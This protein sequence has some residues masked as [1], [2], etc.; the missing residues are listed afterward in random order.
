MMKLTVLMDNTATL[1]KP[2]L[3]ESGLGFL[4]ET[5]DA[6]IIFDTGYSPIFLS[7]A[8]KMGIDL[9]DATGVVISH[10]HN[11]HTNGLPALGEVLF[12]AG[13]RIPL[14][15]HPGCLEKKWWRNKEGSLEDIGMPGD[16]YYFEKFYDVVMV[17]TPTLLGHELF[18]LGEI[19]RTIRS[20]NEPIGLISNQVNSLIPDFVLDDSAIV[21][22]GQDG[23]VVINGCAHSGLV[24]ILTYV[25]ELFPGKP[26]SA[27]IGGFHMLAKEPAWLEEMVAKL[28]DFEPR[29]FYPCHCTDEASRATLRQHFA[30]SDI[31]VGSTFFFE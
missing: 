14:I 9:T 12:R 30:V 6:K 16:R 7:N 27:V 31:S 8:R 13:K 26:I 5:E 19:P 2:Y 29:R 3:A 11:D 1:D 24:N 10:G 18:F 21:Y 25:A 23:L 28:K 17:D 15:L 4:I 20:A 22:N